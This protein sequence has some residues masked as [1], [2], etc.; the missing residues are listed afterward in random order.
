MGTEGAAPSLE[1]VELQRVLNAKR[2]E[3][4][5]GALQRLPPSGPQSPPL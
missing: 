4:Q 5:R 1:E 2:C 3:L